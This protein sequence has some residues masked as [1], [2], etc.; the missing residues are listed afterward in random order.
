MNYLSALVMS[1]FS[2]YVMTVLIWGSS[3]YV[4]KLH[5]TD[6]PAEVSIFYRFALAAIILQA[7]CRLRGKSMI[8]DWRAHML[9]AQMG[10]FLFFVNFLLIYHAS[11]HMTTGLVSVIFTLVLVFN[12]ANGRIFLGD[13]ISGVMIVGALAGILGIIL[14]FLPEIEQFNFGDE[15]LLSFM[16][17]VLGTLSASAGMVTSAAIQRRQLPVI[18]SNAWGMVYGALGMLLFI[19][20]RGIPFSFDTTPVYIG[21]LLFLVIFATILGFGCFLTLVGRI[22]AGKAAYATVLFPILALAISTVLESYQW[23]LLSLLGVVLALG[24]N[25]IILSDRLKA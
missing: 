13:H 8:Y 4:I 3:W 9:F 19:L 6:V 18:R 7:F 22:G 20:V 2:L 11:Y 14:V 17:A 24:G 21:S 25:V 12:M 15:T 5:L 1:T 16:L 10:L 23:S